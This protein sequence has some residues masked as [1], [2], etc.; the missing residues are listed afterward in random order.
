VR[1]Y[2]RD[3]H[4]TEAV[5]I[6][7]K[8]ES[9]LVDLSDSEQAEFLAT[10]GVKESGVGELIRSVYHLLGL[11]TY[12]TAGEKETRAWTIRRGTKAP[13]AAGVIHSDFERGFIRAEVVSYDVLAAEGSYAA[14]RE[15]GKLRLEGKEYV[16]QDGDVMLFRF[17]V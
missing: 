10:I 7:A 15:K 16:V 3:H 9:D 1:Q 4:D 11:I 17:N 14:V 2:A 5:V 6:S 12:L 8:I 13:G